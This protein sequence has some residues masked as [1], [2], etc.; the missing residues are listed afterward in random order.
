MSK[1]IDYILNMFLGEEPTYLTPEAAFISIYLSPVPKKGTH[2][3]ELTAR[4]IA[5]FYTDMP[6]SEDIK[7]IRMALAHGRYGVRKKNTV[8]YYQCYLIQPFPVSETAFAMSK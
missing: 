6:T 3:V 2:I 1:I 5:N 7:R 4:D 8:I